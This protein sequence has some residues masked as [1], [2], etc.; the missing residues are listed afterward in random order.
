MERTKACDVLRRHN[1]TYSV[2]SADSVPVQAVSMHSLATYSGSE[3]ALTVRRS[4]ERECLLTQAMSARAHWG[5]AERPARQGGGEGELA[6][7][8][9]RWLRPL[10]YI[11]HFF[12]RR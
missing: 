3:H 6:A 9:T 11:R 8:P 12:W 10:T 7:G 4:N 5:A 2:T 1:V